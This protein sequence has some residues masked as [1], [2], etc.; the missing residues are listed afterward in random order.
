MPT[1]IGTEPGDRRTPRP[2]P[3]PGEHRPARGAGTDP[4]ARAPVEELQDQVLPRWFVLL[5]IA[6]VLAAI[7]A[8][9]AAFTVFGPDEVPLAER[10]PPPAAGL[11]HAVGEYAVGDAEPV[12]YDEAC[13]RLQ[14]VQ[15]AGTDADRASLRRG[16]AAVC[17]V[18]E[19]DVADGLERF[20]DAGGVVRFATFTETGVASTATVDGTTPPQILVNSR[21]ARTDPLH[22]APLIAHDVVAR[23]AP[24]DAETELS[25]RI[26]QADVCD[27]LFAELP[28]GCAEATA[29]VELPDALGALRG[30]GYE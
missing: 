16:L 24:G 2:Q 14:G 15:V 13:P 27:R 1:M 20:A 4:W 28:Q 5:G 26:S 11:T 22:I 17:N 10:R 21:F 23:T 29:L 3:A 19:A 8:L 9:V 7:G 12:P 30:A 25:A 18:A 6:A